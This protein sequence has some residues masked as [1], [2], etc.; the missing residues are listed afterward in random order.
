MRKA[1]V[2]LSILL[3]PIKVTASERLMNII[4]SSPPEYYVLQVASVPDTVDLD[5]VVVELSLLRKL[6]A[7]RTI[8]NKQK[9]WVIL[10]GIYPTKEEAISASKNVLSKNHS[11]KPWPRTIKSLKKVLAKEI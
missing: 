1:L 2:S 7:V 5:K 3:L 11:I 6:V 8:V 10:E 9:R 4:L